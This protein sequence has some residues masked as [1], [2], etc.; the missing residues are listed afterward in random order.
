MKKQLYFNFYVNRKQFPFN[1]IIN[2]IHF[3]CLEYYKDV[4]DE[5][6]INISLDDIEDYELIRQVQNKFLDI[7]GVAKKRKITFKI[8]KNNLYLRETVFFYEEILEKL[9]DLDLVFF[10]HNKG[11]TNIID[12]DINRDDLFHWIIGLYYASLS[13]MDDVQYL[14]LSHNRLMYGSFP[15]YSHKTEWFIYAGTFY[16]LNCKRISFVLTSYNLNN[17]PLIDRFVSETYP[18]YISNVTTKTWYESHGFLDAVYLDMEKEYDFY[19]NAIL[20][21]NSLGYLTDEFYNLY[22]YAIK[23]EYFI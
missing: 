8:S 22:N 2:N 7:F 11:I 15:L 23:E 5:V 19:N 1:S 14:L 18:A 20:Y 6:F 4:F 17:M 13:D 9:N 10:A 21:A 3:A 16:W 12:T